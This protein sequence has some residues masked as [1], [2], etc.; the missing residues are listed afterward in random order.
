MKSPATSA[1]TVRYSLQSQIKHSYK[2]SVGNDRLMKSN[3]IF[4]T[5]IINYPFSIVNFSHPGVLP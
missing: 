3:A 2:N 1:T 4:P 5:I